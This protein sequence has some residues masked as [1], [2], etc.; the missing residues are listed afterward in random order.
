M[1]D[2][3]GNSPGNESRK[4]QALNTMKICVNEILKQGLAIEQEIDPV[5]LGLEIQQAR[6]PLAV[7]VKASFE[8]EKDTVKARLCIETREVAS[9]SRCLEEFER[10]SQKQA[11]FV[12]KPDNEH[13]IDLSSDIRD[14]IF[15]E[16]PINPLCADDCKGLCSVCGANLNKSKC[17]CLITGGD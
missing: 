5:G 12:Y 4:T 17:R 11:D 8:R 1:D 14:T 10:V 2:S 6:Y 15:L 13:T 7:K 9:C 3:A 16:R